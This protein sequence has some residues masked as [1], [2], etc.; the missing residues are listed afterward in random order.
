MPARKAGPK[1]K[2]RDIKDR[3]VHARIPEDLD[4]ELRDRAGRFGI[5]VS[6]IVCNVL[7]NT[8]DLV[9]GVVHDSA[10]IARA[11]QGR[12][13]AVDESPQARASSAASPGADAPIGCQELVL[14]V[15]EHCNAILSRGK[16]AAV[17]IPVGDRPRLSCLDCLASLGAA[18]PE[19]AGDS[20]DEG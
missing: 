18:D 19:M 2:R 20:S 15:C 5:S 17:G 16:R 6:T 13:P 3:V 7:M 12:R 9:E 10:E 1:N 11:F 4:A 8:F 14:N